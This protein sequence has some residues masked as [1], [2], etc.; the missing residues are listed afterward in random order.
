MAFTAQKRPVDATW[1]SSEAKYSKQATAQPTQHNLYEVFSCVALYFESLGLRQCFALARVCKT[2]QDIYASKHFW[3]DC[4]GLGSVA[5]YRN[6]PAFHCDPH[7]A[8]LALLD[9]PCKNCRNPEKYPQTIQKAVAV[10]RPRLVFGITAIQEHYGKRPIVP[11]LLTSSHLSLF[12]GKKYVTSIA[13]KNTME[14]SKYI[15]ATEGAVWVSLSNQPSDNASEAALFI[16]QWDLEPGFKFLHMQRKERDG[17]RMNVLDHYARYCGSCH[18]NVNTNFRY[19]RN[20]KI[21]NICKWVCVLQHL[22]GR[23]D[24]KTGAITPGVYSDAPLK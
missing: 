21:V 13:L 8:M 12:F 7:T 19:E 20:I 2:L 5:W 16:F 23:Y 11:E 18:R 3:E 10:L 15:R 9:C 14:I 1:S 22:Y 24:S 6:T 17:L 4:V